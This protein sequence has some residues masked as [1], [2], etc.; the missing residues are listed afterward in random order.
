L[1]SAKYLLAIDTARAKSGRVHT[2]AYIRL[3]T[4]DLYGKLGGAGSLSV[5]RSSWKLLG[6][7]EEAPPDAIYLEYRFN[8]SFK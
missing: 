1:G 4:M 3:P 7:G 8:F 5:C 6:R 2:I